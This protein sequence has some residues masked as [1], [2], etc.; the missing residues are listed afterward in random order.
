MTEYLEIREAVIEKTVS[1][2]RKPEDVTLI[3]VSKGVSFP[4]M[5]IA[6]QEG[7]R[8]FGESRIQEA[9]EKIGDLSS[10][11]RWHL[12]GSLQRNKVAKAIP[13]F[14]LIHSVDA[15]QLA[16]KISSVSALK[17]VVTSILL[18]VNTSGEMTK[19]GLF[20]NEW[21]KIFD[22]LNELPNIQ[23]QGLMTIAPLTYD[24]QVIRSCFRTLYQLR[25]SWRSKMKEPFLF[26]HLSMGMS[27]DYS[28][29]IEE[30]AT[31][32]RIGSAIFRN[33]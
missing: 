30:G 17:N 26:Q 16:E 33:R 15:L 27:H 6:Y 21:E 25:E 19:H 3:A 11:C 14:H 10:D 5:R 1:C 28:I 22:Q 2:G 20:P 13:L 23:I 7:C 31:L 32:L 4:F 12:I 29:A 24:Q 9:C 8:D 18:Q